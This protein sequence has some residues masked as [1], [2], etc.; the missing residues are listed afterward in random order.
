MRMGGSLTQ[1]DRTMRGERGSDK[2][3]P[4]LTLVQRQR[5]HV[6]PWYRSDPDTRCVTVLLV[7][8]TLEGMSLKGSLPNLP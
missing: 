3:Y 1:E 6:A 7:R 5:L 8:I 4:R 2:A